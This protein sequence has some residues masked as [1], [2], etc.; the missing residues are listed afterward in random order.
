MSAR[1]LIFDFFFPP[2]APELLTW[3]GILKTL[4]YQ[5][6]ALVSSIFMAPCFVTD[7]LYFYF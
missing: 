1:V 7:T 6:L 3:D 2:L 4:P 5:S